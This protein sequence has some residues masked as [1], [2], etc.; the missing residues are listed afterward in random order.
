[1]QAAQQA[2]RTTCRTTNTRH[3]Y[4]G[5]ANAQGKV[6]ETAWIGKITDTLKVLPPTEPLLPPWSPALTAE[7]T[8]AFAD[9]GTSVC[10]IWKG[11]CWARP[12]RSDTQRRGRRR[13]KL[14]MSSGI[15]V[16]KICLSAG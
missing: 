9:A 6:G 13:V 12:Y 5:P 11:I 7:A 3:G 15:A 2:V 16:S 4:R 10:H 1:M 8:A 14:P